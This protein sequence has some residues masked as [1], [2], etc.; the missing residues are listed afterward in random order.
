LKAGDKGIPQFKT[1]N[2]LGDYQKIF[3]EYHTETDVKTKIMI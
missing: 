2:A 3:K 1:E